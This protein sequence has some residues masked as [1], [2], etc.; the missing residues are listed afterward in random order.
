[1]LDELVL[2]LELF[3]VQVYIPISVVLIL[4]IVRVESVSPAINIPF[5]NH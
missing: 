3:G 5:L 1:M 2:P 4:G